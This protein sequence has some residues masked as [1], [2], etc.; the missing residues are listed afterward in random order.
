[1]DSWAAAPQQ[2]KV[3]AFR[4]AEGIRRTEIG[5][6]SMFHILQG[7]TAIIF[8]VAIAIKHSAFPRW[9]GGIG[10]FAGILTMND[11]ISV[12]YVGFALGHLATTYEFTYAVLVAIIGFFM[13]KRTM[14]KMA[15]P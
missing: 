13:W 7:A 5:L 4:V 3:V 15:I 6:A 2:E 8:G 14:T 10:V 11:G 1:V 12:A 9:V